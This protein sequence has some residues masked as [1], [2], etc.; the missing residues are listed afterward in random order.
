MSLNRTLSRL[1]KKAKTLKLSRRFTIHPSVSLAAVAQQLPFTYTGADFYA[2]CS[3]AMLKAV[4]RQAAAVDTKI[5]ALNANRPETTH[6]ISTANFFDHY[7]TPEDIAVMVTEKDFLDANRELIPSVSAGELAHYQRVRATF[8]GGG[9]K[10]HQQ[11]RDSD[12]ILSP[13]SAEFGR[14]SSMAGKGKGKAVGKIKG[15]AVATDSNDEDDDDSN[16]SQYAS[17]S[18]VNGRAKGKGKAV[19]QF[20]DLTASDDEGLY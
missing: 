13:M 1:K 12:A 16:A 5:R 6:P 11:E 14:P 3:D 7:A 15:K 18:S 19:A 20:Q 17:Y 4:T 2:M 10:Q 8:E 9:D